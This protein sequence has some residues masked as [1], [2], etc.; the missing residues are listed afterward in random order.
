VPTLE[1]LYRQSSCTNWCR[2]SACTMWCRHM[3]QARC[4]YQICPT[5]TGKG[6]Q[7]PVP[8]PRDRSHTHA[9]GMSQGQACFRDSPYTVFWFLVCYAATQLAIQVQQE[10][11]HVV[12]STARSVEDEP[13]N[14]HR[15]EKQNPNQNHATIFLGLFSHEDLKRA[16]KR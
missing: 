12:R 16:I 7:R 8:C 6:Q 4:L 15:N 14:G 3:V 5:G 10:R 13:R 11:I 2:Q 9:G 1:G